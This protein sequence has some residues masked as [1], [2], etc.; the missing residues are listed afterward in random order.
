MNC[1]YVSD[2]RGNHPRTALQCLSSP[3]VIKVP[4]FMNMIFFPLVFLT[5]GMLIIG[6]DLWG[7]LNW[8][9]GGVVHCAEVQ[10]LSGVIERQDF[11]A[12]ISANEGLLSCQCCNHDCHHDS[13]CLSSFSK[14]IIAAGSNVSTC[15]TNMTILMQENQN[16]TNKQTEQLSD[17][18]S[19]L[20]LRH[21]TD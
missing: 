4:T 1:V 2:C 15:V 21:L 18:L 7:S 5:C 17:L 12:R 16:E 11:P 14:I 10:L 8:N 9:D 6:S 3:S 20:L 13:K 19:V